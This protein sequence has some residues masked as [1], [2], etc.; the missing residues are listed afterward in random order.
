MLEFGQ[1]CSCPAAAGTSMGGAGADKGGKAATCRRA[2]IRALRLPSLPLSSVRGLVV[3]CSVGGCRAVAS[4]TGSPAAG[5]AAAA[6]AVADSAADSAGEGPVRA[7]HAWAVVSVALSLGNRLL[8]LP[9]HTST[10]WPEP[11]A[12]ACNGSVVVCPLPLN[13]L[14]VAAVWGP[15]SSA[16]AGR[17]SSS[18]VSC[19][20]VGPPAPSAAATPVP[21]PLHPG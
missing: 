10:H 12:S 13:P 9:S 21:V 4:A 7:G 17:T 6:A 18:G 20:A 16:A 1:R 15:P 5:A 14:T 8:S 11:C 19:R 2:S 3:R